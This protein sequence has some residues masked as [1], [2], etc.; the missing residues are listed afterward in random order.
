QVSWL[1]WVDEYTGAVLGT[2][3]FPLRHLRTSTSARGPSSR[4]AAVGPL[5]SAP[6]PAF[7]QRC[8]LGQLE[9]PADA[10]RFVAGGPGTAAALHRSRLAHAKPE[11]RAGKRAGAALGRAG[12]LHQRRATASQLGRGGSYP[13]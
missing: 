3:V 5:G 9:R 8:A 4:A 6:L 1:R 2:V 11:D 7:G 13:P 12:T 10:V